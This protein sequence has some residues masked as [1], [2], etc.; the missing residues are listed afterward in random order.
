MP[1]IRSAQCFLFSTARLEEFYTSHA[2]Y[3]LER[4][5]HPI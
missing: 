3:I 1:I 5:V 4:T 2:L